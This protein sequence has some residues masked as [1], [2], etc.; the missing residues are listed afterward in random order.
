VGNVVSFRRAPTPQQR[1]EA[2][3]KPHFEALYGAAR[4]MTLSYHDAEDLVQEVCIKAFAHLD[5]LET[6][7]YPRAWLLKVMYHLFVDNKRREE[8]SAI[9]AAATG[10]DAGQ[11]ETLDSGEA[12]LDELIDRSQNIERVL[13]AMRC[14][15][16]DQCALVAMH[17]VE[18]VSI[19]EL[20]AMTGQPAG[21]IRSQLHRTR[22]KLGRLLS[23]D[24]IRRLHL[25]IVGANR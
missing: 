7:E 22:R 12:S 20:C 25:K 13:N 18:G 5:R 23:N 1:F 24:A 10:Q 3:I 8:R 2:V 14:L 4:R 21:T 15:D 9:D 19:A 17:D 16:P 6:M 11:P